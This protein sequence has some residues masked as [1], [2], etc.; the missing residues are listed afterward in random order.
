MN[1]SISLSRLKSAPSEEREELLSTLVTES[2]APANGYVDRVSARIEEYER[3]Y[4]LSSLE[5]VERVGSGDLEETADV[6]SWLMLLKV[7]KRARDRD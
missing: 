2:C 4:E 6:A 7:R 1:G 5:A 3:R